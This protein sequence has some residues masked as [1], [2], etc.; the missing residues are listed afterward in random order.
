MYRSPY[1][2]PT[3]EALAERIAREADVAS[4]WCVFDNTAEGAATADALAVL[5]RLRGPNG[6]ED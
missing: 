1:P 6:G 4:T 3:L 2:A 5:G